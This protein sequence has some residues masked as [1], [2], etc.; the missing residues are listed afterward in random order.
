MK[1]KIIAS[2]S[3]VI[4][5]AYLV[6]HVIFATLMGFPKVP[7]ALRILESFL[8]PVALLCIVAII[9]LLVISFVR[10]RKEEDE[11][12]VSVL[13]AA[14]ATFSAIGTSLFAVLYLFPALTSIVGGTS[15]L[16][17]KIIFSPIAT[18][19][20]SLVC[21]VTAIVAPIINSHRKS[22]P[23]KT[24]SKGRAV[25]TVVLTA[26]GTIL[27]FVVSAIVPV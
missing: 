23:S 4:F 3:G 6:L 24:V 25:F 10:P 16:W 9:T 18:V 11:Q 2:V 14:T 8:Y 20:L 17:L 7:I 1:K 22:K 26:I 13:W 15:L 12:G 21:V 5:V 27:L 19:A